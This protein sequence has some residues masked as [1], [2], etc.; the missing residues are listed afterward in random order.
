MTSLSMPWK[1]TN[2]ELHIWVV[3]VLA[4]TC[5]VLGFIGYYVALL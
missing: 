1:C 5:T 4:V 3:A 2:E